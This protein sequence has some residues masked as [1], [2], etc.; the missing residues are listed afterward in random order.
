MPTYPGDS[1]TII[2]VITD[3]EGV[4]VDPSSHQI[5]IYDST[6][7][8]KATFTDPERD[9]TGEYHKDYD[10]PTDAKIGA[11]KVI[12]KAVFADGRTKTQVMTFD[13]IEKI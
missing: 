7:V 9:D 8:L 4:K 13:V 5:E 3:R 6:S 10:L 2:A 1:V 12:W 11:W